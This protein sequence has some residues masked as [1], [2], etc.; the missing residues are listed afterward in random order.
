LARIRDWVEKVIDFVECDVFDDLSFEKKLNDRRPDSLDHK[1]VGKSSD[2][3]IAFVTG[4]ADCPLLTHDEET[5]LFTQMNWLKYRAEQLRRQLSLCSPNP[6]LVDQIEANLAEANS[7][8]NRIVS[9]NVRLVVSLARK[10]AKSIDQMSDLIGESMAPLIRAVELFDVSLGN[11]FSTYAT[12]AVRNHMLRCLKRNGQTGERMITG[13]DDQLQRVR[14]GRRNE[15]DEIRESS[16]TN[17]SLRR[18]LS[19]LS[20]REQSIIAARFGLEG[21]P[22][23]QSLQEI[24]RT[25]GLSKE[26]VRQILNTSMERLHQLATTQPSSDLRDAILP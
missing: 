19:N 3:G 24:A 23:G 16:Q 26:R 14:D 22:S 20:E 1:E 5:Y 13:I 21:Q 6:C 25:I 10:F 15:S 11:R 18:L 8:R 9:S 7:V 2:K 17:D 12:W 4:M